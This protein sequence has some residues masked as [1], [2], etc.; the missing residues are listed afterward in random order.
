MHPALFGLAYAAIEEGATHGVQRQ[1]KERA[2]E[3]AARVFLETKSAVSVGKALGIHHL[4]AY[5]KLV[6]IG[7]APHKK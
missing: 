3:I 4:A 2:E 6:Q 1:R 7:L 5:K